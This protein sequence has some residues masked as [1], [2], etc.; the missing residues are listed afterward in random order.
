M[1]GCNR[2]DKF[3]KFLELDKPLSETQE[4]E[5]FIKSLC[6]QVCLDE[7]LRT[8]RIDLQNCIRLEKGHHSRI[9]YQKK[10]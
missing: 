3:W 5:K 9:I 1:S 10:E 2:G 6:R 7:V 8:L 4:T